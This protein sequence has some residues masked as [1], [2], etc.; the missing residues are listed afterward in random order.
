[1]KLK[2]AIWYKICNLVDQLAPE[3]NWDLT[4]ESSSQLINYV[5]DRSD[6]IK[7]MLFMHLK[8]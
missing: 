8:S 7:G 5:D 4:L 6:M 3:L 1:M 2:V